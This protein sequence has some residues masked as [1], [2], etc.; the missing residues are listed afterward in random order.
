MPMILISIEKQSSNISLCEIFECDNYLSYK[1]YLFAVLNYGE[2]EY[3]YSNFNEYV[4]IFLYMVYGVRN[5]TKG[6]FEGTKN[7]I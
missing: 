7:L 5:E 4:N 3:Y 6:G 1:C 2:V